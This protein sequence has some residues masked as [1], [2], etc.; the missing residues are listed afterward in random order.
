[1]VIGIDNYSNSDEK[2]T[3]KL[4]INTKTFISLTLI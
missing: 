1:M 4:E 2:N 3:L